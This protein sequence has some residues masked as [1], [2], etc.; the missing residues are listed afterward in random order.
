MVRAD[1]AHRSRGTDVA[2]YLEAY[3]ELLTTLTR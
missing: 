3:T 1:A 2:R